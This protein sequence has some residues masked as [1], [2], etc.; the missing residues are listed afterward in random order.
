MAFTVGF[1]LDEGVRERLTKSRQVGANFATEV[2][3][4]RGRTSDAVSYL[5]AHALD[6]ADGAREAVSARVRALYDESETSS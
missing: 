5:H 6:E 1:I 3:R 4:A 2:K